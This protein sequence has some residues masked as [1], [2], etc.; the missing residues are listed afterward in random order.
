MNHL[1]GND[2]L[3]L[4]VDKYAPTRLDD[5]VWRDASMREKFEEWVSDGA[6]PHLLFHGRAGVGKT[7]LAL[8]LLKILEIPDGDILFIKASKERKIDDFETKIAG[9]VQTYT[10]IDNPTGVKYV[11]LDEADAMTPLSQKTLRSEMEHYSATVRFILTCNYPQQLIEPLRSRCQEF[12]FQSL[13]AE[14]FLNRTIGILE[15]ERITIDYGILADYIEMSYP[16]MRK[17]IGLLQAN[18]VGGQLVSSKMDDSP[19]GGY[20]EVISMF[21]KGRI[22]PARKIL[23]TVSQEEYI[24]IYRFMYENLNLFSSE[25]EYQDKALLVIRDGIYRDALVAD[26]E[27]NLSATICEL[28]KIERT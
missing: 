1:R 7:S 28:A 10:M 25:E 5:Y 8:L 17:C 20:A 6:L 19:E 27:I 23:S 13:S 14:D 22:N 16:D 26:R 11:I 4:W 3:Q 2:L 21:Q 18:S 9:F 12:N 24:N 15:A